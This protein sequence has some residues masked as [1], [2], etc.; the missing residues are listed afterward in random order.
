MHLDPNVS[1]Y[2]PP[3]DK[4][5]RRRDG[6][7]PMGL[8]I[9]LNVALLTVC[10][11]LDGKVRKAEAIAGA[12]LDREHSLVVESR[13]YRASAAAMQL[14]CKDTGD[15]LRSCSVLL[16]ACFSSRQHEGDRL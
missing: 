10:F 2:R 11:T 14:A 16:A 4:E 7:L 9:A 13:N 5:I 1:A 6:M 8:S 12:S 15:A 3:S